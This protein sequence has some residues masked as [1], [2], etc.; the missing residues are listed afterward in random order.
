VLVGYVIVKFERFVVA[1]E[2][3]LSALVKAVG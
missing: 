2:E 3:D 1:E